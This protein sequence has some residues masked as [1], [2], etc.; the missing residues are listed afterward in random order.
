MHEQ[1]PIDKSPFVNTKLSFH[2]GQQNRLTD[3]PSE[4][5]HIEG[6]TFKAV[7][8]QAWSCWW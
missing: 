8:M 1:L 7:V 2:L 5:K 6:S 3:A 4:H